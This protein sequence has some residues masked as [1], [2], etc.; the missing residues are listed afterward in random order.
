MQCYT[1]LTGR[2]EC[3]KVY[4]SK[5]S[6]ICHFRLIV[7]SSCK[8]LS[9]L[10]LFLF[11]FAEPNATQWSVVLPSVEHKLMGLWSLCFCFAPHPQ[12]HTHKLLTSF[13]GL[14]T[15]AAKSNNYSSRAVHSTPLTF[16]FSGN[17]GK[18]WKMKSKT[19]K[20]QK[21]KF[22]TVSHTCLL[23]QGFHNTPGSGIHTSLQ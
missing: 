21:I 17:L 23:E 6:L 16:T 18:G 8:N 9:S 12:P 3:Y 13:W 15:T 5:F 20:K 19:V 2:N 7:S 22:Q 14:W 10:F 4:F 1:G 11:I